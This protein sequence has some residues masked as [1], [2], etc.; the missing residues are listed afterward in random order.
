MNQG[1]ARG[2]CIREDNDYALA[3]VRQYG[4]GRVFYCTIAHN[5][6][7]FWDPKML[8]FYLAATQFAL[9]DLPAPTTPSAKLTPAIRAH[10]KLGWQMTLVPAPSTELTL[11]ETIDKA[12]ELGLLHVGGCNRQKVSG[13]IPKSFDGRLSGEV[14]QRIRLKLDA[15]GV[16]LSAYRLDHMPSDEA[17]RRRL[18]EFARRMG[19]GTYVRDVENLPD[20]PLLREVVSLDE[21]AFNRETDSFLDKVTR[22]GLDNPVTLTIEFTGEGAG[23]MGEITER[24]EFFNN[25]AIKM[26][27]GG[28]S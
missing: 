16:H 10:E 13:D 14:L 3:W 18:F 27:S 2:N 20:N 12:A 6:Y 24:I 5:P 9:G 1:A 15:V 19:A 11:F 28:G 25:L 26:A 23:S 7:V 4:R 17:G 22:A 21:L 8:Q